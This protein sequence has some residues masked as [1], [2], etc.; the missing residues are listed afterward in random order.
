MDII[1]NINWRHVAKDVLYIFLLFI[2]GAFFFIIG[3][4]TFE[5]VLKGDAWLDEDKGLPSFYEYIGTALIVLLFLRGFYKCAQYAPEN[6]FIH[7]FSVALVVILLNITTI[8]APIP[9]WS[10]FLQNMII[11]IITMLSAYFIYSYNKKKI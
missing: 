4:L 5:M 1:R 10:M 8:I 9:D 2:L 3:V 6:R 7:M 11:I